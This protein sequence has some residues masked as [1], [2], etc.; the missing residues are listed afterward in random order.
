[1]V[2]GITLLGKG[3]GIIGQKSRKSWKSADLSTFGAVWARAAERS[4]KG[5]FFGAGLGRSG[6]PFSSGRGENRGSAAGEP[7]SD[8]NGRG[9]RRG[10]RGRSGGAAEPPRA[11]EF[12]TLLG[13]VAHH[14][15]FFL[16]VWLS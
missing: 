5:P 12:C 13:G 2:W 3:K 11:G 6:G 9:G 16:D 4:K 15:A 7:R 10:R 14:P 8:Q 1:M